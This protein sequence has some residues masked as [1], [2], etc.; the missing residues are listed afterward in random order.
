MPRKNKKQQRESKRKAV[1]KR[2]RTQKLSKPKL[3]RTEPALEEALNHR[4]PLAAC[5]ISDGWKDSKK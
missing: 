5:L 4:H 3:L 1:R 2:L